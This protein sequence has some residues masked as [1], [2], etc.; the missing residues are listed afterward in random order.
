[1][2]GLVALVF[3]LVLVCY[4]PAMHGAVLWDD[5]AHIPT[6]NMRGW[7]G[8]WRMWT[9]LRATQQ[10]YPVLF[11]AFWVEHRLWGD[12]MFGYHLFNALL[13]A[14]NSCLL[15]AVVAR[16]WRGRAD[17]DGRIAQWSAWAAALL[18]A[19]HPVCVESVAWITEQ[20]NTLS[21]LFALLA[22]RVYL[23]YDETRRTRT[24]VGATLLFLAAIGSKTATV[25]L[26][27]I[28]LALVWWRRGDLTWR[29]DIVP[30][31]PW[32]AAAIGFGLL[33]NWVER[34]VIGAEGEAYLLTPWQRVLLAGRV[35]WFFLEKLV[36]PVD[37]AFFYR[38]WDV[39][40]ESGPWIVHLGAAAAV[41]IGLWLVRR[42]TRGPFTAWLALGGGLFP[43]LGFFNV[44]S[45]QFSYVADHYY[46][47]ASACALG[48][49]GSGVAWLASRMPVRAH[50]PVSAVSVVLI[51]A[52][53]VISRAQSALYVHNTVLFADNVRKVPDSWMAHH[54]LANT[55]AKD[56]AR[57]AE[58]IVHYREAL[59]HHP[60]YPDSHLGL[61]VEL[62]KSPATRDEAI[63]LYR[64]A[65]ELRPHY[66]EA[67]NN[68]G[69]LLSS[70]PG[71]EAEAERHLRAALELRPDFAVARMNLLHL[72]AR[73]PMRRADAIAQ[74]E[75][76][77]RKRPDSAE[78]HHSLGILLA[79]TPGREAEA[80]PHFREAVRLEPSNP[81]AL[82]S[83]GI[84][85]AQ[86]GRLEEAR[87]AWVRALEIDPEY[88]QARENL[89][90]LEQ[91]QRR[92]PR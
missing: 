78:A 74:A 77:L 81:G 33:T 82:N 11:S 2:W 14:A 8:L 90:L 79:Q 6:P 31:L 40:T 47:V 22:T 71:S 37:R 54:I 36:W 89:H 64:R 83:L 56:P 84:A 17:A 20:K 9:D 50:V 38:R 76:M 4:W 16:L 35:P 7:D 58:A 57:S 24:Y 87:A 66:V 85:C 69:F 70:V 63:A 23:D 19:V 51:G 44:F 52:L 41:T 28:L 42:R 75:A 27:P 26:P 29:R 55:L 12:S 80:L 59:R 21:L 68:L 62:A 46:Y 32:F 49:A 48:A 1:M 65:I 67:L 18:F 34:E 73:Q 39:A 92:G 10:Y 13:H 5:P 43:V 61:A 15:G 3:G 25:V 45:F 53:A 91:V 60:D 86:A 30:L 88:R 72:L